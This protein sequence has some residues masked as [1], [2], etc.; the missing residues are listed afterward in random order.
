MKIDFINNRTLHFLAILFIV[1]YSGQI[2]INAQTKAPG[3]VTDGLRMWLNSSNSNSITHD[4]VNMSKWVDQSGVSNTTYEF[5]QAHSRAKIPGYAACSEKMNFRPA[6]DIRQEGEYLM[7]YNGPMSVAAPNDYMFFSVI[8]NN[9]GRR[10]RFYYLGFGRSYPDG[11]DSR[12]PALGVEDK[13]GGL[14]VGRYYESGGSGSVEGTEH[15]FTPGSTSIAL[16]HVSTGNG[17]NNNRFVRFEFNCFGETITSGTSGL[18]TNSYLDGLGTIGAASDWGRNIIGLM[19]EVIAYERELNSE[20]KEAIYSYLGLKYAI[21]L[22]YDNNDTSINFDYFISDKTKVWSGTSNSNTAK[23]HNNIA[24]LVR[25]DDADLNN[26]QARSTA[27]GAIIHM[28]IGRKLGCSPDLDGFSVDKASIIWGHDNTLINNETDFAGNTDICGDMDKKL[29]RIWLVE[30]TGID[31]QAVIISPDGEAFP[32]NGAGYQLFLLVADSPQK[33]KSLNWDRVVPSDYIDG[34]HIFK[35]TFTEKY[36][37]FAIG[38]KMVPGTCQECDFSGIRKLDFS[39]WIKGET[40][41]TFDLGADFLATIET[42]V[43]EPGKFRNRYPRSSSQRSLKEYRYKDIT[44]PMKTVI[45][46]NDKVSGDPVSAVPKFSVFEID[47]RSGMYDN[48]KVYGICDGTI[49][50]AKLSYYLPASRSTYTIRGN[51]AIAKRQMKSSYTSAQGKMN[52]TFNYPVQQVIVEHTTSGKTTGSKRIG[53]GAM[54]FNCPQPLPPVNEYG[55]AFDKSGPEIVEDCENVTYTFRIRNDN[56]ATKHVNFFDELEEGM[57]WNTDGLIIDDAIRDNAQIN[58]YEGT[59]ILE[60][61]DLAVPGSSTLEFNVVAKFEDDLGIKFGLNGGDSKV[62]FNEAVINYKIIEN[63]IEVNAPPLYTNRAVITANINNNKPKRVIVRDF[64]INNSCYRENNIYTAT[65]IIDN[66]NDYDVRDAV[67][68]I[69]YNDEFDYIA[70]SVTSTN[71]L[72]TGTTIYTDEEGLLSF[73][74][75]GIKPGESAISFKIK[76]PIKTE[77]VQEVDENGNLIMDDEGKIVYTTFIIDFDFYKDNSNNIC[78]DNILIDA[79][80]LKELPYCM[81]KNCVI[82]NIHIIPNIIK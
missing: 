46:F 21:T 69:S 52:V 82:S 37:Y 4:N 55:L 13:G 58:S 64:T 9:F 80:G 57:I 67:L 43:E 66:P 68:D 23:Y 12:R 42:T 31:K 30:K 79:N 5:V 44:T 65:I 63:D 28:G 34:N 27:P 18:G 40:S 15:I 59:R 39:D 33:I 7:T 36:T 53:I 6:L 54:E 62:F 26:K 19:S 77:L 10:D 29:D 75:V 61:I 47:Y 14:Y 3:G 74:N 81:N 45:S 24:A 32:Y 41:R 78:D 50:P 35:H 49:I 56:C 76:A 17:T 20:E 25:D 2:P 22:D 72:L 70:N 8:N 51:T 73:E 11:S 1:V 16:Q 60:I 48:V 38:V 71:N